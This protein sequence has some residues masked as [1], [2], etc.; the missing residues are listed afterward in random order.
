[1]KTQFSMKLLLDKRFKIYDF[2]VYANAAMPTLDFKRK[3]NNSGLG[4]WQDDIQYNQQGT[5]VDRLIKLQISKF[6]LLP[7]QILLYFFTFR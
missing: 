5:M 1:M 2:E 7:A 4:T 6:C 3:L